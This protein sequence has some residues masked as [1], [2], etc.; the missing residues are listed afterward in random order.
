MKRLTQKDRL[1]CYELLADEKMNPEN[2]AKKAGYSDSVAHSKAYQWV[3]N[4]KINPK[5]QVKA[6]LDLMLKK[7]EEN[8]GISGAR[9]DAELSKIAYSNITDIL[10]KM[11]GHINIKLLK[12][13]N[14][15]EKHSIQEISE[16]EVDGVIT[17]KLKLYNKLEA[18][19]IMLKRI[20]KDNGGRNITVTI[21]RDRKIISSNS[22]E[23]TK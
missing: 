20:G 1:F 23:Q 12:E 21:I 8:L 7:R 4:S 2:A 11:G 3:S 6:F 19:K 9:I 5:P 18:I 22:N 16:T 13:L 17:R 10:E 14:E 15:A